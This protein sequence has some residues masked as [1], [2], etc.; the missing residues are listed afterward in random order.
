MD[1]LA[2]E[3]KKKVGLFANKYKSELLD[4]C[5]VLNHI[6]GMLV[7]KIHTCDEYFGELMLTNSLESAKNVPI[8]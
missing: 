6:E 1:Q 2:C 7:V 3:Q 4:S 5:D 8:A